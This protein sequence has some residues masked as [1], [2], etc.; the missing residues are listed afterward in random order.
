ML[1]VRAPPCAP[2]KSVAGEH[3][4][5]ETEQDNDDSTDSNLFQ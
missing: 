4:T 2:P 5:E 3:G 1:R